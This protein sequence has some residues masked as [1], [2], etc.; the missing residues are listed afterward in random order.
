MQ[1]I[2]PSIKYKASY[3]DYIAELGAEERYPFTLDFE[4]NHFSE[5]LSKL[6]DY[7]NDVNLPENTVPSSTYWLVE[8]S[9]LVGVTNIRHFLNERIE[10][11]GGHIGLGI[12]P[13]YRGKGLGNLLMKRSIEKLAAMGVSPIHIHCYKENTASAKVIVDNG[14]LLNSEFSES[15]KVI[16]RFV[17]I[18]T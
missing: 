8:D 13:T 2:S 15:G 16:Q 5:L 17:V 11:C 7:S 12:R 14:G 3:I 10:Y 4:H 18:A 6:K 1:L 9:V